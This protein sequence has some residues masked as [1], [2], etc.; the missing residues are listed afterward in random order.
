[1]KWQGNQVATSSSENTCRRLKGISLPC[2]PHSEEE[3]QLNDC[4]VIHT[5]EKVMIRFSISTSRR[6][7]TRDALIEAHPCDGIVFDVLRD[8]SVDDLDRDSG[9]QDTRCYKPAN[10]KKNPRC[11]PIIMHARTGKWGGFSHRLRPQQ[12]PPKLKVLSG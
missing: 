9:M 8:F 2:A 3:K 1:M 11:I 4:F 6:I 5:L 12:F 7:R 10:T